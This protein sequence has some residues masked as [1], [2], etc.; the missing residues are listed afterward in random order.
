MLN[1]IVQAAKP[2]VGQR[3]RSDISGCEDLLS[4][5][6]Q[7]TVTLEYEHSF[8]IRRKG[9]AHVESEKHLVH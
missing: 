6:I 7:R 2:E 9:G 5:S 8:M 1:L 3:V 4:E